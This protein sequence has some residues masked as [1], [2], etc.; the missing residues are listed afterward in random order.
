MKIL[1]PSQR[2]SPKTT[3]NSFENSDAKKWDMFDYNP[4]E[5][6]F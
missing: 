5:Q 6:I 1:I 2:F 4:V 3:Q